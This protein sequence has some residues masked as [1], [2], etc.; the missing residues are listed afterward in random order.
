MLGVKA[1]LAG[2]VAH[3]NGM[4][5]VSDEQFDLAVR[6]FAGMQI[7]THL[8][9]ALMEW[10]RC[11]ADPTLAAGLAGVVGELRRARITTDD[12]ISRIDGLITDR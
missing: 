11:T 7:R 4:A 10:A 6:R 8:H 5:A 1:I 12:V 9:C 3:L 2:C